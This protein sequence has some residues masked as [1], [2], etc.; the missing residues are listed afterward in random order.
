M[1]KDERVCAPIRVSIIL[2]IRRI[3]ACHDD[4]MLVGL[5]FCGDE[6]EEDEKVKAGPI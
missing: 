3:V 4:D 2:V 5:S 1:M 6:V